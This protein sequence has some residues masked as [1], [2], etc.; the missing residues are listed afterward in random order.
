MDNETGVKALVAAMEREPGRAAVPWWPWAPLVQL[1]RVLPPRGR[2]PA[3][4]RRPTP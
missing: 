4:W 2:A 3:P 1:M